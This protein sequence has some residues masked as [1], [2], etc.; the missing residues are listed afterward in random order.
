[1]KVW[2]ARSGAE[3]LTLRG[4]TASVF[5]VSYSPDSTR[6]A[7]ASFD[8][9]IKVWDSGL[10]A[11][12]VYDPW[13]EDFERRQALAPIWHAEDA[14]AAEKAGDKFAAQFHRRWLAEHKPAGPGK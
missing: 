9:T 12:G 8:G 4:H 7:S 10:P 2:D 11:S 3:S 13:V 5:A 14:E 1:V 6:L